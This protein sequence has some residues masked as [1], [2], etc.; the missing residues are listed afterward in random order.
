MSNIID[1]LSRVRISAVKLTP[2]YV[3]L[4]LGTEDPRDVKFPKKRMG[5]VLLYLV[6]VRHPTK[7]RDYN[8]GVLEEAARV[9]AQE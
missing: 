6:Q 5:E 3:C 8:K 2:D 4:T 1:I 9:M 7:I